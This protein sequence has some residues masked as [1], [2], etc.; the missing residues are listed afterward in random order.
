MFG[1]V[2]GQFDR[3]V[4]RCI[5]IAAHNISNVIVFAYMTH[6]AIEC[7][8]VWSVSNLFGSILSSAFV[9]FV[10]SFV[11]WFLYVYLNC[12]STYFSAGAGVARSIGRVF[13]VPS[14]SILIVV[15]DTLIILNGPV[16][17][18]ISL[19]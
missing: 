13:G 3:V 16:C 19:L 11:A 4:N 7:V 6:D 18:G 12:R 17:G 5:A 15:S 2:F 10:V 9:Y 1:D 14:S 8:L